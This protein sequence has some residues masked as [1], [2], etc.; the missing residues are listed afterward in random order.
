VKP[1]LE[2]NEHIDNWD[3][4]TSNPG[5]ILTVSG[6]NITPEIIIDTLS[7]SGYNAEEI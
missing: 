1:F 7:K 3:I 2:G 6:V 5:K 4:D